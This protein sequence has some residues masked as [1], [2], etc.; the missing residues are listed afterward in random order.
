[1]KERYIFILV[2]KRRKLL[3]W[4]PQRLG[5][6]S[7][8]L[9]R[10]GETPVLYCCT[11]SECPE[12]WQ[13]FREHPASDARAG[14]T[15]PWH[16]F[17]LGASPAL[18][19]RCTQARFTRLKPLHIWVTSSAHCPL[20]NGASPP[21]TYYARRRRLLFFQCKPPTHCGALGSILLNYGVEI[22]AV[23]DGI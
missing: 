18:N 14:Q 10:R 23:K 3:L 13:R 19:T 8:F 11:A 9:E 16:S 15:W 2:H 12:C 6:G 7:V 4:F 21:R 20:H 1:M 17:T 22:I 5:W